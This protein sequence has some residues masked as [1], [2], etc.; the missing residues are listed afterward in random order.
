MPRALG[1]SDTA[2]RRA[3][4]AIVLALCVCVLALAPPAAADTSQPANDTFSAA[5]TLTFG[6]AAIDGTT[7]GASAEPG[8]PAHGA[9]LPATTSVW[10]RFSTGARRTA[11]LRV[12]GAQTDPVVAVYSGDDLGTLTRVRAT[13]DYDDVCTGD[14]GLTV[15]LTAQPGV[16]YRVAIDDGLS[17]GPGAFTIALN[18]PPPN[19]DRAHAA[20]LGGRTSGDLTGATA[21][22]GE[23]Q[24]AGVPG[25]HSVW[26]RVAPDKTGFV[27]V[28]TCDS[29][30][31]TLLAAYS[32]DDGGS[33]HALG[34]SDDATAACGSASHGSAVR[35]PAVAGEVLYFAVDGARGAV[36]DYVVTATFNDDRRAAAEA[37]AYPGYFTDTIDGDTRGTT[38]EVDEPGHGGQ[39]GGGG[40]VWYSLTLPF[41]VGGTLTVDTCS[42]DPGGVDTLLSAYTDSYGGLMEL[43][44]S[45]D[46]LGCGPDGHGSRLQIPIANSTILVAIDGKGAAQGRF[47]LRLGGTPVNDARANAQNISS[48]STSVSGT[49]AFATHEP[50]EPQHAGVAGT[51]SVWYRWTATTTAKLALRACPYDDFT[52]TLAVYTGGYGDLQEVVSAS[53]K[54][55]RCANGADVS[56]TAIAGTSYMIAVDGTDGSGDFELDLPP[57]NDAFTGAVTLPEPAIYGYTYSNTSEATAEA[58]E[59]AH[60]GSPARHSL[61]YRYTASTTGHTT[62]DTCVESTRSTRLAVYRGTAVSALAAVAAS[63]PVA[64]CAG[65]LG[66]RVTFATTAGTSYM[67]AVDDSGGAAFFGLRAQTAPANDDRANAQALS[68]YDGYATSGTTTAATREAGE[69]DHAHASGT[70][71]VWFTWTPTQT[72]DVTLDTC[73]YTYFD[74]ALAVYTAAGPGL[75]EVASNDDGPG[76]ASG[77]SL[78]RFHAI[79]GTTYN[80]AVDGHG[81]STGTFF[82]TLGFA[83]DNDDRANATR[84]TPTGDS[85]VSTRAATRE[86]GEPQ[87][88]GNPGGHSVWFRFT[89]TR[90]G[91]VP[92]D[93][94]GSS[95]DTLLAVYTADDAALTPVVSDADTADCTPSTY[96]SRVDVP[97]VAG[98]TYWIAIDGRNGASG[99]AS[100]HFRPANDDF[101]DAYTI[102]GSGS[103]YY[104]RTALAGKQPGEPDHAGVAAQ[105]SVW[106]AW[107]P[108]RDGH[109]TV[110]TCVRSEV[111]TRIAV[112]TGAVVD[113]LTP[114][115]SSR[116]TAGCAAGNGAQV[117]FDVVSGTT[118]R[119]AVDRDGPIHHGSF[120]LD[121][122]QAPDNDNLSHAET[123]TATAD[124]RS[125]STQY[126]THEAGEPQHAGLVGTGSVWYRWTPDRAARGQVQ[127]C[128]GAWDGV[129]AVYRV[130]GAGLAGLTPVASG[131]GTSCTALEL[132]VAAD[133]SYMIAV[134][135]NAGAIGSFTVSVALA[136][137]NDDR[138]A[139]TT[140]GA[141]TEQVSGYNRLATA[142]AGEPAHG[143]APASRSVWYRWTAPATGAVT[144]DTCSASFDTRLAV[145]T[146]DTAGTLT[147]VASGDDAELC[148]NNGSRVAF[149]ATGGTTYWIAVDGKGGATGDFTL[150]VPPANDRFDTPRAL[151]PTGDSAY[152]TTARAGAEAGEPAH[153]GSAA[154]RSVWFTWR[155]PAGPALLQ[156]C[157]T[158]LPRLTVYT[159]TAVASLTAVPT[160]T[161]T[162]SCGYLAS[163]GV[164]K[165]TADGATTYRIALD[166]SGPQGGY[167]TMYAAIPPTNDDFAD[168]TALA[169]RAS[170]T[171]TTYTATAEPAE[172]AHAGT[173]AVRSVW[174]R[175]TPAADGTVTL[176]TCGSTADTALAVY[177][178]TAITAL[179]PIAANDDSSACGIGSTASRVAFPATAGT[180]YRV[181]VET[182]AS[183]GGYRLVVGAP[184]NDDFADAQ[185]LVG[186]HASAWADASLGTAQVGEPAAG[187]GHSLWYRWTAPTTGTVELNDC[188]SFSGGLLRVFAGT[189]LETLLSVPTATIGSCPNGTRVTLAAVKDT[190][191]II[192]L[193]LTQTSVAAGGARLQLG[194]PANDAFATP[195]VLGGA[196]ADATADLRGAS[197]EA[198]EP[199]HASGAPGR[200]VWF[201]WTAPADGVAQV[202][203]CGSPT[204]AVAAVYSGTA[205]A[206]LARRPS[207]GA[208]SCDAGLSGD[209]QRFTA[210]K[211]TIY[212][213]AVD[214]KSLADA[215]PIAL[216]VRQLVDA[217][218]PDTTLSG[219]PSGLTRG[220]LTYTFASTE[221]NSTLQCSVD[222]GAFATCAS[223]RTFAGLADGHHAF[224]FRAVD[225]AGNA[226]DTPAT[227]SV[228]LDTTAPTLTITSA[229]PPDT[230]LDDLTFA[231]TSDDAAAR[232]TCSVD[233]SAYQACLSPFTIHGAAEN[234]HTFALRAT[235]AA[236]N[237]SAPVTRQV[238]VDHTPPN[239]LAGS[240]PGVATNLT[241]VSITFSSDEGGSTFACSF[242]GAAY[243]PCVSPLALS[244]LKEGA[245][246]L[247]VRA[248]D[249]AAN[250]DP[251][252]LAVDFA[253][254]LTAPDT[255]IDSAPSG[256][257]HA[258]LT[259]GYHASEPASAYQCAFDAGAFGGCGSQAA[260]DALAVGAHTF[261]VRAV[262]QAGNVDP[263]PATSTFAVTDAAPTASLAMDPELMPAN[264]M[265]TAVMTASDA[266]DDD[267]A[268][269]IDWGDDSA[270]AHG[271]V[272]LGTPIHR[273]TAPGTYAVRLD[274]SDRRHHVVAADTI[275]VTEPE[276]LHADAGDDLSGVQ[277]DPVA[278]D[279]R[280]S[281]PLGGIDH[282]TWDFGDG[283]SGNGATPRHTYT[284]PGDYTVKLTV[285]A[286]GVSDTDTTV[287]HVLSAADAHTLTTTVRSGG[288][289]VPGAD[290]L[291][292]DPAG[293]RHAATTGSDGVARLRGLADGTYD[294]MAYANG[295]QPA[296][297]TGAVSGGLGSASVEL[298]AG[299]LVQTSITSHRMTIDEIKAAG[300]DPNDPANQHMYS[301]DLHLEV[302]GDSATLGGHV[303]DG[304]FVISP[305]CSI[306]MCR[307][308]VRGGGTAYTTYH[309][310][311]G[312]P[313]LSTMVI[314]FKAT[315]LKE[316]F[317]I[318]MSVTNLADPSF[319]LSHAATTLALPRGVS[320]APTSVPQT[321]THALS[322][323][324]GGQ[325]R[326][327]RWIVRGDVEGEYALS[328]GWAATLEPLGRSVSGVATMED[329]LKVW[330]GSA[331]KLVV[332]TDDVVRDGYPFTVRVGLKN[333]ADVPVYNP[334]VELADEGRHGYVPQPRQ[335]RRFAAASVAPGA[336][337]WAGPFVLVPEGSGEVDLKR[338]FVRQVAG[339]VSLDAELSTTP[340]DPSIADNPKI[341]AHGRRD[342]VVIDFDA[343]PGATAYAVHRLVDRQTGFDDTP[344]P[345]TWLTPTKAKLAVPASE[346]DRSYAVSAIVGGK[347]RMVHA[348]TDAKALDY[349][350]YPKAEIQQTSL[351]GNYPVRGR[352]TLSDPDVPITGYK[353]TFGGEE[354]PRVPVDGKYTYSTSYSFATTPAA[355]RH[356]TVQADNGTET[357]PKAEAVLG[358]CERYVALGDSYSSG[359]GAL[360]YDVGTRDD[361]HPETSYN[362]VC[363]RSKNAYSRR[364]AAF[365][366]DVDTPVFAACSGALMDDFRVAW[367]Q[368]GG[369][370]D[371][372]QNLDEKRQLGK[373]SPSDDLVTLTIGGNDVYFADVLKDCVK[374]TAWCRPRWQTK[375]DDKIALLGQP[376]SPLDDLYGEIFSAVGPHTRVIVLGYA[377]IFTANQAWDCTQGMVF[378]G[379]A[380][381]VR[382]REY[383]FNQRIKALAARHGFEYVDLWDRF[384]GHE[385]CGSDANWVNGATCKPAWD[386]P[387]PCDDQEHSFHPNALGHEQM[388]LALGNELSNGHPPDTTLLRVG[389]TAIKELSVSPGQATLVAG[390]RWPGSD[391]ELSL[392]SPSGRVIDRS[393]TAADVHRET[394]PTSERVIVDDPQPGTWKLKATGL[395]LDPEGEYVTLDGVTIPTLL[396]PPAAVLVPLPDSTPAN[397]DV[398]FDASGSTSPRPGALRAHW[399]FGDGTGADGTVVKHR[400]A[401]G[402]YRAVL[403]ITDAADQTDTD[404]TPVA[405]GPAEAEIPPGGGGTG[406][407]GNGGGGNGGGTGRGE[408]GGGSSGGTGS[409][410]GGGTTGQGG[411]LVPAFAK[412]TA[413]K[414]IT[415]KRAASPGLAV[416]L[417]GVRRGAKL[418]ATVRVGSTK[419]RVLGRV[420]KT[421][422][423]GGRVR[424][425]LKLSRPQ[426]RRVLGLRRSLTIVV[427]VSGTV[428]GGPTARAIVR[429]TL[430]R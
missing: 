371:N 155:P 25:G 20:W 58:G 1:G 278:F 225:A 109:A 286:P 309:V 133:K 23:P 62:L 124:S 301:F 134:D 198:S 161:V 10:Y 367:A 116:P 327:T 121:L 212:A 290:V 139:A 122:G 118:Y 358:Q 395:D 105:E 146:A 175:L 87:H 39:A 73:Q 274:V 250:V 196:T 302:G 251:T 200:T 288:K 318:T 220:P 310:I 254:D 70:A 416:E 415:V 78:V 114:V 392:T 399:D 157:G 110:G 113:A 184:A 48:Y 79:A 34:A 264:R 397:R 355:D 166:A 335:Q 205:L 67:I 186:D 143:G 192:G 150:G 237:V 159:G 315:F 98:A 342:S 194:P 123:L 249:T 363:H 191:Y 307:T 343:I 195:T 4:H 140:I 362:N 233:G 211:S 153:A 393:T 202:D 11:V 201:R 347:P 370:K 93:T 38:R 294:V 413:V 322:D 171:G 216:R 46:D 80:I 238:G 346:A 128:P 313:L 406:G 193:D 388:A 240:T 376:G 281:R 127:L 354:I 132:A 328:A 24:H 21:E 5:T 221:D 18:P 341:S 411:P 298:P 299:P 178:G 357:G 245:H 14:Y 289:A 115:A 269:A 331:L 64:G 45:D 235:D 164:V 17:T 215:G 345:V 311:D 206:Q 210:T 287:V 72:R 317:E 414:A 85:Y 319:T 207:A 174:Y 383:I 94:C 102:Y 300:I 162:R 390:A 91:T 9:S 303:A 223:P 173:S 43:A 353:A 389:E 336:T 75:D 231:F 27:V 13:R 92:I 276:P 29:T 401:E 101:A 183:D 314:P 56:F 239:T 181:A 337:F 40:S 258:S 262:D 404:V 219:G 297:G 86:A 224:A 28:Q 398:T 259:F 425:V 187:N 3:V 402:H 374:L 352:V 84:V 242:D 209:V 100:L 130:D 236:G 217:T 320:L 15:T 214:A 267:L 111:R 154:R 49:T 208:G 170:V 226:D 339:D 88:A 403:T 273:Y 51:G 366:S 136:P 179:T 69:P 47:R 120:Q 369:H 241:S 400:Y 234:T 31:D 377:P 356:Y 277:D 280:G 344:L 244:G 295:Y 185:I 391:V 380:A 119:I 59:P 308:P 169:E 57:V 292:V 349:S 160:R 108:T 255:T 44:S 112:Y 203:T 368:D 53:G 106:F 89:A 8:E 135:G 50:N 365:R 326:S 36:G 156:T 325:T 189:T 81:G 30:I 260:F 126:A 95:F 22:A 74:T 176:K 180:T 82:L 55:L 405:I 137:V 77:G 270:V 252:P 409:D 142:E 33:L 329:P 151:S 182:R 63:G 334:A 177:T 54:S 394:T 248:T 145:Y 338:S 97:V 229:P 37:F 386:F 83:P 42:S 144:L 263:T 65:G 107:T 312:T 407:A 410:G 165:F 125:S 359:E 26:Y 68:S 387:A 99:Y 167:Y 332:E 230:N 361:D 375:V 66:A 52:A 396:Q 421:A 158:D 104:G 271:V 293:T 168:A 148:A 351:C 348:L 131:H 285:D 265:A 257:V 197:A 316:F 275:T 6:H 279:A 16:S 378:G 272:G 213:I 138:A 321:A 420:T 190:T 323:I 330:G 360:D 199:S 385:V 381:W 246:R 424:L 429:V 152:G 60:A 243:A 76:C 364:L 232:Y 266:E 268:Y 247:L 71:S 428:S 305:S 32:V 324:P 417:T 253:V 103:T 333:V 261:R 306:R 61:W 384:A 35:V 426:L 228:D 282:Y 19:D 412:A 149:A 427:A 2:F 141:G 430:R 423:A 372:K 256:P 418:T 408:T 227:R 147:A 284:Q 283:A 163:S 129:V 172:P 41:G 90:A 340:R 12:C 382:N 117:T 204:P 373:L 419:G 188:G 422:T 379:D 291:V 222:A 296:H 304:G 7:A 350:P 218:P 96:G